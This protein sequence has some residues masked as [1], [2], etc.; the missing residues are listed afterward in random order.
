MK[1]FLIAILISTILFNNICSIFISSSV[2][3]AEGIDR[4][5]TSPTVDGPASTQLTS[6]AVP[7]INTVGNAGDDIPGIDFA[8]QAEARAVS[9]DDLVNKINKG[10]KLPEKSAV[11]CGSGASVTNP[12][13]WVSPMFCIIIRITLLPLSSA[14]LVIVARS[15]VY[16]EQR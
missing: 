13:T 9:G 4:I 3:H 14:I 11:S 1:K 2:A 8:G 12:L 6:P 10:E 16:G 7:T 15:F 5:N